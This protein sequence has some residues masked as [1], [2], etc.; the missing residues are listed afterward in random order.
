MEIPIQFDNGR[1][2]PLTVYMQDVKKSCGASDV[3]QV[4]GR[5][6]GGSIRVQWLAIGLFISM[7]DLEGS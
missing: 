1:F 5:L 3:E 6:H 2:K 4:C 7:N